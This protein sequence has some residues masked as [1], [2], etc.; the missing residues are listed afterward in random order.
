MSDPRVARVGAV[1]RLTAPRPRP[2][3][4]DACAVVARVGFGAVV[5]A[6]TGESRGS[7]AAPGGLTTAAGRMAGFTGSYLLLTMVVLAAWLPWLESSVGQDRLIRWHRKVAP[8]A[9]SSGFRD[10]RRR[11]GSPGSLPSTSRTL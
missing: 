8:W 3:V 10:G 7:L 1:V 9:Y 6:I 11:P 4:V 5:A 2:R